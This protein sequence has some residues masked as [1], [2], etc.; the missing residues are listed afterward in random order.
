MPIVG[1]TDRGMDFPQIGNIRKGAEKT[2]N[3]PGKEL[4]HWRIIFD[5]S[6]IHEP[7][8]SVTVVREFINSAKAVEDYYGPKTDVLDVVLPFPEVD[9][10]L[11]AWME[12]YTASR[13]V[14]RSNGA[15]V[16]YQVFTDGPNIGEIDVAGWKDKAGDERPHPAD[17]VAGKDQNGNEVK[18][19]PV[20]RLKV[21]LPVLRRPAYLMMHTT[22]KLDIVNLSK[23]LTFYHEFCGGS[24][25][26]VP[27]LLKRVPK[28]ISVPKPNS[29]GQRMR[30]KKYLVALEL[31]PAWFEKKQNLLEAKAIPLLDSGPLELETVMDDFDDPVEGEVVEF[32]AGGKVPYKAPPG[33]DEAVDSLVA[34]MNEM[35]EEMD[36]PPEPPSAFD[37]NDLP[38]K[39]HIAKQERPYD[40]FTTKTRLQD[41][42]KDQ[43]VEF[44]TPSKQQVNGLNGALAAIF[45]LD[46][47]SEDLAKAIAHTLNYLVGVRKI[48]LLNSVQYQVIRTN[49]LEAEWKSSKWSFNEFAAHEANAC[50]AADIE[51]EISA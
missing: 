5:E 39:R 3:R 7:D 26:G 8:G 11:I 28:M 43:K 31:H 1:M 19:K 13:L 33:N 10:N 27:F 6:E 32:E 47:D 38:G 45:L 41:K 20:A 40:A 34:T 17:D 22:S 30:V 12:A 46:R 42:M 48:E 21:I 24:L 36:A 29:P 23:Q 37:K 49:W 9:D 2:G 50:R 4:D 25:Q 44:E 14:G 18:Y 35:A 16:L 51:N 15:K